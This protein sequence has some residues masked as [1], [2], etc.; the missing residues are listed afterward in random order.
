MSD[1]DDNIGMCATHNTLVEDELTQLLQWR[2]V[3]PA[4]TAGGTRRD[5]R[6]TR[7]E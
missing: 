7:I 2:E 4:T 6:H 5:E 1:Y 3:D